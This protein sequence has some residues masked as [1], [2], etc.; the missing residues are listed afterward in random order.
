MLQRVNALKMAIMATNPI[1][2]E[3]EVVVVERVEEGDRMVCS[4]KAI[5]TSQDARDSVAPELNSLTNRVVG[6]P[7]PRAKWNKR[8]PESIM[9]IV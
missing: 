6:K 7:R 8:S 4:L 2:L 1:R 9:N 3:K 5:F